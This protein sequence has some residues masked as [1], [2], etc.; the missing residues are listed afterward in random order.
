MNKDEY[1]SEYKQANEHYSS[2]D[3]NSAIL[4]YEKLYSINPKSYNLLVNYANALDSISKHSE[5]I[6]FYRLATKLDS[7]KAI[8][9]SNLGGCYYEIDQIRKAKKS[10][11][12]ALKIDSN[13]TMALVNMGNVLDNE[14]KKKKAVTFYQKAIKCDEKYVTAYSNLATTFYE[15]KE[16]DNAIEVCE[17]AISNK[18]ET[19]EIYLT[20][21]NSYDANKD[22][23][24]A[25]DCYKSEIKI[26]N[27]YQMAYNN[28]GSSFEKIGKLDESVVSYWNAMIR[29]KDDK[30]FH[31]NFGYLLY[32]LDGQGN[33][34][35]ALHYAKK[36]LTEFPTNKIAKH[37]GL[38]I[39]N[40][41][42][43]TRA[44]DEYLAEMFDIFAEDFE[45]TLNDLEYK[46]P[47]YIEEVLSKVY[48][49]KDFNKFDIADLGCGTGFCAKYL[50]HFAKEDSGL[51]GVDISPAM[52]KQA[53]DKKLYDSLVNAEITEY[54]KDNTNRFD[55][56]VSADVFTYFGDLEDLFKY[57]SIS[58]KRKGRLLFTISENKINEDEYFLHTS[59]R[60]VHKKE[61]VENTL[62]KFSLTI[63]KAE[64]KVLRL[65]AGKEVFG[66]IFS[67]I[68]E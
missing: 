16:Y 27:E 45:K 57:V 21:G 5:A 65:E 22:Y 31:I 32:E 42:N 36:W 33:K 37:M 30:S 50:K 11:E 48:S 28:L 56:I 49:E 46:A 29:D 53:G 55:L 54:L 38:A 19:A 13:Y 2:G 10:I 8:A 3:Y 24:T 6:K 58:L 61:Y 17:K 34:N 60:F 15:L 14:G 25:I 63:E 59:G 26:D 52:L 68:K 12:K 67:A 64:E 62:K 41:K 39:V 20:L 35:T 66:F 23:E 51:I 4:I 43:V 18:L 1:L 40:S 47:E 9:W 44:N 7:K